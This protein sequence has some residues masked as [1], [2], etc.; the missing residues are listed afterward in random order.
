M[1][2]LSQCATFL[3]QELFA[4]NASYAAAY[5]LPHVTSYQADGIA[6]AACG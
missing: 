5:N 1:L 2:A 4:R 6:V 3:R